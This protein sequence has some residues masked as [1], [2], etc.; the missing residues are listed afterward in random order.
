MIMGT[1]TPPWDTRS[2]YGRVALPRAGIIGL[3]STFPNSSPGLPRILSRVDNFH[4][5]SK[6]FTFFIHHI[7]GFVTTVEWFTTLYT[8]LQRNPCSPYGD[9]L[10]KCWQFSLIHHCIQC[11]LVKNICCNLLNTWWLYTVCFMYLANYSR[12]FLTNTWLV[13]YNY[14]VD[15]GI[16]SWTDK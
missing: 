11:G 7:R 1:V 3:V 13:Y 15:T 8:T 9:H 6:A 12:Y 5:R 16:T 10:W 4:Q 2:E 14:V